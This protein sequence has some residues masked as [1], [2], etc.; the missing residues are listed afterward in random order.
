M[1]S[2][3]RAL[4]VRLP[5]KN[6]SARRSRAGRGALAALLL[7]AGASA[8]QPLFTFLQT[9]DSQAA[10]EGEWQDFEDVLE[11]IA[12]AGKPGALQIGRAHV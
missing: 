5:R 2:R 11:L 12:N 9:S 3:P 10:N 7:A 1:F 8:Q 4:S 6:T